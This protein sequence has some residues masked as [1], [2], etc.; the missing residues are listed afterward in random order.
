M[1]ASCTLYIFYFY[2]YMAREPPSGPGPPHYRGSAVTLS[3]TH[4]T[5]Q[6]SSGRG[7]GPSQRL[8]PDNIQNSKETSLSPSRIRTRNPSERA[9]ADPRLRP[10]GHRD[11]L[12]LRTA[13]LG[14][15]DHNCRLQKRRVHPGLRLR[16]TIHRWP[17]QPL[18]TL[19]H[20]ATSDIFWVM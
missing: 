11:R 6:F 7:I 19:L 10:R 5:R 16:H 17:W 2:L 20:A 8:L 9:V 15:S 18:S 4:H 13:A 12:H 14:V 3:Y 1:T